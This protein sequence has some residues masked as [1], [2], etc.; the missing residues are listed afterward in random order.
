MQ[1]TNKYL[2]ATLQC[3]KIYQMRL[4][5]WCSKLAKPRKPEQ[6][7]EG[8]DNQTPVGNRVRTNGNGKRGPVKN[9]MLG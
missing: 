8:C 7:V 6:P 3:E 9:R 2:K 1:L 4:S 5:K